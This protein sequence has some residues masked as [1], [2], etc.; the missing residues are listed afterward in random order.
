MKK[1]KNYVG[2]A[3]INGSCPIANKEE[4]EERDYEIIKN[5]NECIF[6]KGCEDCYFNGNEKFPCNEVKE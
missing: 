3:C 5:C 2:I 1:C 4:Y 6:Y